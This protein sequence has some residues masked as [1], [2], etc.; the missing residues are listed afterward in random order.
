MIINYKSLANKFFILDLD[1][2][3]DIVPVITLLWLI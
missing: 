2:I 1:V 3:R